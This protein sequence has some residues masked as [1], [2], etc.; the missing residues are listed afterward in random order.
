VLFFYLFSFV[1]DRS[2]C[3]T[4]MLT[5]QVSMIDIVVNE[6]ELTNVADVEI[7]FYRK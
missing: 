7:E 5:R 6:T 1:N 4:D 3:C 2:K